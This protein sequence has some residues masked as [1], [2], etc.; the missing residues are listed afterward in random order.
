MSNNLPLDLAIII[1]NYNG[2]SLLRDCIES[3]LTNTEGLKYEIVVI[4]N[5]SQDDSVELAQLNFPN[6]RYILNPRNVGFAA[7]NNQGL[8]LSNATFYALL[9]NDTVLLNNTFTL[10]VNYLREQSDAAIA[11]PKIFADEDMRKIQTTCFKRFPSLSASFIHQISSITGLKRRF[12]HS[13]VVQWLAMETYDHDSLQDAAHLNGACLVVRQSALDQVGYLDES[14]FMYLEE[15]DWC[16]RF[17]Q[18]GWRIAFVPEAKLVHF[19]AS[20]GDNF[21]RYHYASKRYFLRKHYGRGH[22]LAYM[23]EYAAMRRLAPSL[24]SLPA[25]EYVTGS[26]FLEQ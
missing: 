12:P 1:V 23:M 19:G 10:L 11:G 6:V 18:H 5:A 24:A 8:A 16:Y 14:Y 9:N 17:R 15:T 13:R 2:S 7:A 25:Q 22:E 20:S 26:K 21:G 3:I 4:D